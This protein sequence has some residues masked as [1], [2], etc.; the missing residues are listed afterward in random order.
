LLKR[1]PDNRVKESNPHSTKPTVHKLIG[2]TL[3][4]KALLFF[5]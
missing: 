5:I 2:W 1:N 3:S 4:A